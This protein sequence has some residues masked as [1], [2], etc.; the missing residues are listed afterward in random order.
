MDIREEIELLKGEINNQLDVLKYH[1][2]LAVLID[3]LKSEVNK[4]KNTFRIDNIV[5]D[6]SDID[7]LDELGLKAYK[8][9]LEVFIEYVIGI[10]N[11]SIINEKGKENVFDSRNIELLLK[12]QEYENLVEYVIN[13]LK[14]N[15]PLME[16]EA[17]LQ[18]NQIKDKYGKE[19]PE[20]LSFDKSL[21]YQKIG[22]K[23]PATLSLYGSSLFLFKLYANELEI[24]VN[25]Y[26]KR[27]KIF[28]DSD[29]K[30]KETIKR[31]KELFAGS[32]ALT[33]IEKLESNY[34]DNL[35]ICMTN[36]NSF[37]DSD[38]LRLQKEMLNRSL[39]LHDTINRK[40]SYDAYYKYL[41]S[42]TFTNYDV[43][44]L[45]EI[46]QYVNQ[47]DTI[48]DDFYDIIY[49]LIEKEKR[50]RGDDSLYA[51]L[52]R[53]AKLKLDR[54][55]IKRMSYLNKE[56]VEEVLK[57][58][59]AKGYIGTTDRTLD[60]FF[61]SI[62]TVK[63]KSNI[64]KAPD[65]QKG[66][67]YL[68]QNISSEEKEK[69]DKLIKEK[70][71][72]CKKQI[73]R[74]IKLYNVVNRIG[75]DLYRLKMN[76]YPDEYYYY[77]DKKFKKIDRFPKNVY[78]S[79][80]AFNFYVGIEDEKIPVLLDNNFNITYKSIRKCK[81]I[82][83]RMYNNGYF[84]WIEIHE[85]NDETI[86]ILDTNGRFLLE[87]YLSDVITRAGIEDYYFDDS[88]FVK[89]SY[90]DGII[91]VKIKSAKDYL[92]Y[93]YNMANK[94]IIRTIDIQIDYPKID[95]ANGM[96]PFEENHRIGFK[97][98][99]GEVV[100][101][102]QY[103]KTSGFSGDLAYVEK[104]TSEGNIERFI[105]DKE[106]NVVEY[107]LPK[108]QYFEAKMDIDNDRLIFVSNEGKLLDAIR[109]NY[110]V[111]IDIDKPILDYLQKEVNI[112]SQVYSI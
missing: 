6:Y 103:T 102:P 94:K 83:W 112:G 17:E 104:E 30:I 36:Y 75:P 27:L 29:I 49:I 80:H 53:E 85:N 96:V 4:P 110:E 44:K 21:Y 42:I 26:I 81:D 7:N 3:E 15:L 108:D 54:L 5:Y 31:A 47:Y 23:R 89:S 77:F 92:I 58:Y 63:K 1:K 2:D 28:I 40:K 65:L 57:E 34:L 74:T 109:L 79:C 88:V 76:S 56:E 84:V 62:K 37:K 25:N 100:I 46:E 68:W 22:I 12:V 73:K 50:Y 59:K 69:I 35:K 32:E 18:Y 45:L 70:N 11:N 71:P 90:N 78:I 95:W 66:K 55:F 24:Y 111:R 82:S 48:E 91:S 67:N 19:L 105:I 33:S 39:N 72:D 86:R 64:V 98:Y 106:G 97:N 8:G 43:N 20:S 101:K 99:D 61:D 52:S 107:E 9:Y 38:I 87:D 16:K 13:Y 41:H 10:I 93:L 60:P 14:D 51:K